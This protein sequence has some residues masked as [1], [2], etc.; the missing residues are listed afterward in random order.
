MESRVPKIPIVLV[1]ILLFSCS[2]KPQFD[3]EKA[4]YF[5]GQQIGQNLQRQGLELD[6]G[7][8]MQG[9]QD[10]L[11]GNASALDRSWHRWLACLSFTSPTANDSGSASSAPSRASKNGISRGAMV[12]STGEGDAGFPGRAAAPRPPARRSKPRARHI[13]THRPAPGQERSERLV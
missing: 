4:G 2:R 3:A 1:A 6:R 7:M 9:M 12:R 11:K 13:H 5:V 8:I 10:A